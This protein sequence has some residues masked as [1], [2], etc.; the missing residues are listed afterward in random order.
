MV[1]LN[2]SEGPVIVPSTGGITV[3]AREVTIQGDFTLQQGATM[4]IN[5]S[6]THPL[7]CP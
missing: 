6:P 7:G 3:T 1:D 4:Q 2:Y 5:T